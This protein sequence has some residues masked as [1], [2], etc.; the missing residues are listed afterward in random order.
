MQTHICKGNTVQVTPLITHQKLPLYMHTHKCVKEAVKV[1]N[2]IQNVNKGRQWTG[3]YL[4]ANMPQ[5][6]EDG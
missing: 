2:K 6:T 5:P 1:I 3:I 4:I